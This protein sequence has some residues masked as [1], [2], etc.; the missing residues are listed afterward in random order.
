MPMPP[1]GWGSALRR[2]GRGR[3]RPLAADPGVLGGCSAPRCSPG[4]S[5]HFKGRGWVRTD[6][7]CWGSTRGRQ[8]GEGCLMLGEAEP[9][10]EAI[11]SMR[12][13]LGEHSAPWQEPS[14]ALP[15]R[16]GHREQLHGMNR[17]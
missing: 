15:H 17:H 4:R 12:R 8:Q 3:R 5:Q 9:H 16:M 7:F 14:L 13:E 6:G 10:L 2:L 11:V 1:A